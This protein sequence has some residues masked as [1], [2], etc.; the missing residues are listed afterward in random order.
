MEVAEKVRENRLRRMAVRR[1]LRLEKSRQRDPG[2]E[3]FGCYN[4]IDLRTGAK[5]E[6]GPVQ[7]AYVFDCMDAVES[8]LV[9][10]GKFARVARRDHL[11]PAEVFAQV[12][13]KAKR[14]R[15]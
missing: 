14:R 10:M 2:G 13:P 3:D 4:L 15:N 6:Y 12:K 9:E 8:V 5:L 1:G 11:S 7:I